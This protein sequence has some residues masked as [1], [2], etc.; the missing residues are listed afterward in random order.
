M[1]TNIAAGEGVVLSI[2][3]GGTATKVAPAT[4]KD[5]RGVWGRH[6]TVV[7]RSDAAGASV[8]FSDPTTGVDALA[9]GA[10]E[11]IK[12]DYAGDLWVNSTGA[13]TIV[14]LG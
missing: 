9:L 5:P 13:V 8:F 10:S 6:K 2:S 3:P 11:T 12:L 7:I 14:A 4:G 1:N